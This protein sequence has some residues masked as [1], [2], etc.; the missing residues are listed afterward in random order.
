MLFNRFALRLPPGRKTII[1]NNVCWQ[2]ALI[3]NARELPTIHHR[4]KIQRASDSVALPPLT[5]GDPTW[6]VKMT[7]VFYH[8]WHFYFIL[9]GGAIYCLIEI[10]YLGYKWLLIYILIQPSIIKTVKRRYCILFFKTTHV[11]G[12]SAIKV[13]YWCQGIL[14]LGFKRLLI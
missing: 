10:F 5:T 4:L 7:N 14:Y 2:C 13:S 9:G 11:F 12:G 3:R 6:L 8:L 1:E